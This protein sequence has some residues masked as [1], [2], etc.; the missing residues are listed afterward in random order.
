MQTHHLTPQGSVQ[1][2]TAASEGH[3]Y[4]P[5]L[6][7]FGLDGGPLCIRSFFCQVRTPSPAN[8]VVAQP[9]PSH[10]PPQARG[11]QRM[12]NVYADADAWAEE[13]RAY[14]A[15][16]HGAYATAPPQGNVSPRYLHTYANIDAVPRRAL[17][18]QPHGHPHELGPSGAPQ[19]GIFM[20][21]NFP[22]P[23]ALSL[24]EN[25]PDLEVLV[26]VC[27]PHPGQVGYK[28]DRRRGWGADDELTPSGV[29][30]SRVFPILSCPTPRSW[31]CPP[32]AL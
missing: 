29:H 18:V 5:I 9:Q 30:Q 31:L 28:I 13:P 20:T 27:C 7:S 3:C 22:P 6:T 15:M 1:Y 23:H 24:K 26:R 14:Q 10:M 19:P 16:A 11:A 8:P 17:E 32:L 2:Y 12:H 25:L 21:G 4:T